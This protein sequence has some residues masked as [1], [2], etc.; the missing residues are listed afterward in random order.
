MP[1]A[2]ITVR[3]RQYAFSI[4]A[5][6]VKGQKMT[7]VEVQVLNNLRADNIRNN[8]SRPVLD[9][10]A[11]LAPG[12]LLSPGQLAE[13]QA[14]ISKYDSTYHFK[15]KHEPRARLGALDAQARL[16]AEER[17]E[18][19]VRAQGLELTQATREAAIAE[20]I[21]LPEVQ[22]EARKRVSVK[23]SVARDSLEDLL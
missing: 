21:G 23:Q 15:L 22:E 16:V 2:P 13:L 12:Q 1:E 17:L 4:S 8:V 18:V 9:A 11:G 3:I 6:Y 20:F 5:P 19:Q 7:E 10:I 14:V